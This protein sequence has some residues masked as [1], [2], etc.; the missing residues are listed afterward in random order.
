MTNE[1]KAEEL[2]DYYAGE[3][4]YKKEAA[5]SAAIAM[6]EW[7]EQQMI[8]KACEWLL[9]GG[10]FVNSTETIE[11][12]KKAMVVETESTAKPKWNIDDVLAYRNDENED[13]VG[14]IGNINF[15]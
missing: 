11:D 5:Y 8:E 7:K 14:E 15:K 2:A 6:A 1:K 12:F 13:V 10:Y 9:R 3:T 4:D